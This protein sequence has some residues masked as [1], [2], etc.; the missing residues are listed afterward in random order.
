MLLR[1]SRTH[2]GEA[3]RVYLS[4][5]AA[6]MMASAIPARVKTHDLYANPK[7][8]PARKNTKHG[9]ANAYDSTLA[10]RYRSQHEKQN[11]TLV[12]WVLFV[13]AIRIP[14]GKTPNSRPT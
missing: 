5:I 8:R 9:T 12:R 1:V 4:M 10:F 2:F 3:E 11:R 14:A 7:A 13:R 6:M